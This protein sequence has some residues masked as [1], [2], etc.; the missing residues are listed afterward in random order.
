MKT[1]RLLAA[2]TWADENLP[3]WLAAVLV[4]AFYG[5][6]LAQFIA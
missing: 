6:L 2:L 5:W 4:I 1:N 3:D